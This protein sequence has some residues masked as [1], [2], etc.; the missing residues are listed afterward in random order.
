MFE[1]RAQGGAEN[2]GVYV[3]EW[4]SM[5]TWVADIPAITCKYTRRSDQ[6][7]ADAKLQLRSGDERA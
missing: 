1:D 2:I 4:A 6:V 5:L 7:A 3:E